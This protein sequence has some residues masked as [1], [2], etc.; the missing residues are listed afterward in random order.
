MIL[1]RPVALHAGEPHSLIPVTAAKA[2]GRAMPKL[3]SDSEGDF[4]SSKKKPGAKKRAGKA[5]A[6]ELLGVLTGSGV[7]GG[8]EQQSRGEQE[9]D[10]LSVN[11]F[12]QLHLP[13]LL[14]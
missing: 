6:V 5:K 1:E 14:H 12:V 11:V 4:I 10:E 7:L 13:P 2:A 9:H 8:R 3:E